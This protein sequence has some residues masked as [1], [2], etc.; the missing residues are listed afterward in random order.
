MLTKDDGRLC[1]AYTVEEE[2][3]LIQLLL[4]FIIHI[5]GHKAQGSS[6]MALNRL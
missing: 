1:V 5:S 4:T 2:D 6:H 3:W